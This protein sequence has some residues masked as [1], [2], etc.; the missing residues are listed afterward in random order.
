MSA[1][2]AFPLY[3]GVLEHHQKLPNQTLRR[4]LVHFVLLRLV[5]QTNISDQL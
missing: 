1:T 5:Y 3:L 4:R 2:L